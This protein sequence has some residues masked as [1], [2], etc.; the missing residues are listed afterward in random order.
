MWEQTHQKSDSHADSAKQMKCSEAEV[1][2]INLF[3]FQLSAL[4]SLWTH[5]SAVT[6]KVLNFYVIMFKQH[7]SQCLPCHVITNSTWRG[8]RQVILQFYNVMMSRAISNKLFLSACD[9]RLWQKQFMWLHCFIWLKY[10]KWT[11]K[12]FR[13]EDFFIIQIKWNCYPC[14]FLEYSEE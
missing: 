5:V 12:T 3:L 6:S 1:T 9:W 13:T 2:S 11:M 10:M 7:F 8:M 14:I 4:T